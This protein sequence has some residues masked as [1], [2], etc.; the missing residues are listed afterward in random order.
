MSTTHQSARSHVVRQVAVL[1]GALLA[2]AGAVIGSG[3]F[4][5]TPVDEA[6]GGALAADATHVA[7]AGPAFT[8]WSVI[9]TGLVAYA[10]WQVL[11]GQRTERQSRLGWLV[12]ASLVLNAAWIATV[13]AAALVLGVVV[14]V[15][16]LAVLS[17][18][19]ARMVRMPPRSRLEAVLVDGTLGL[20][21]GWVCVATV[22][23]VAAVLA[24]EGFT[25]LGLG[26]VAWSVLV[27]AVVAALGVALAVYS[28]GRLAVGAAITWGLAWVAVARTTGDLVSLPTA[29]AAG[30]A[31]VVVAV[32]TVLVRVRRA[33]RPA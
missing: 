7:P 3:A 28:G 15:A 9:Y 26:P 5:G 31:A 4:G 23:D 25:E 22:A 10:V 11:P 13:Q 21:L 8:I 30:T 2:V 1:V 33:T 17:L 16:L 18:A 14:I 19:L 12:L 24:A 29:V 27:L 6:A 32:A 20:Y